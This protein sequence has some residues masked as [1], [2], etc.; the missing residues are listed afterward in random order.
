MEKE[1]DDII[2]F[3]I[4]EISRWLVRFVHI[5]DDNF[6]IALQNEVMEIEKKI[7]NQHVK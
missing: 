2:D 1:F 3:T 6:G 4:K 5:N 7:F